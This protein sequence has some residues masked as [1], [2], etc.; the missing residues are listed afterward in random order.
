MSSKAEN[1][2]EYIAGFPEATQEIL[3]HIREIIRKTI[4]KAEEAISYA[5]PTFKLNDS[6]VIYFA[7]YKNHVSLYPIPSDSATFE[8]Q[9]APY[10]AGKGTLQFSLD[11][12]LPEKLIV[13]VTKQNV[14]KNEERTKGKSKK[15]K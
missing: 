5:I 11:K 8:K 6:Y 7:G 12:P 10:R 4:P 9:L 2:D 13:Q 14:K 1:I 15:K 3:E